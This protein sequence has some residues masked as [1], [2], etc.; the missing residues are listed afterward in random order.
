MDELPLDLPR[1]SWSHQKEVVRRF[2]KEMWDRADVALLG[3]VHRLIRRPQG[4]EDYA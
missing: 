3:D 2:Y 1:A 4:Q